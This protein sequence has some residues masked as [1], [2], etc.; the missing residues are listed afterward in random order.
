MSEAQYLERIFTVFLFA[1]V[2]CALTSRLLGAERKD[3][4]F[5]KRTKFS[6]FTRRSFLGE[7][8]HF[9]YPCTWQGVMVFAVL[10]GAVFGIGYLYIF[11]Y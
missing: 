9:G 11:C 3:Q 6:F 1:F 4:W 5:R 2:L 7:F 8:I 10:I